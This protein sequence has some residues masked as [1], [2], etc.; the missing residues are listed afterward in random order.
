[1]T[2]G[3]SWVGVRVARVEEMCAFLEAAIGLERQLER[4]DFVVLDAPNGD[5]L[6]L[7]GPRGPQPAYQF[8]ANP[9]MVGFGVAD[10]DAACA[11]VVA[12]GGELV[13]DRGS[14]W[15]HFRAPDGHVY[16]VNRR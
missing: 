9:V 12:A 15:Q 4:D 14:S 5:R 3:V 2:D 10:I 8:A 16:E 6:E 7:F 11:R 13:G 1:M